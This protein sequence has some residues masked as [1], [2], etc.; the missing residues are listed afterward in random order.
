[1]TPDLKTKMSAEEFVAMERHTGL[2]AEW[3]DG[4][5]YAIAGGSHLHWLLATNIA[6]ELRHRLK[7]SESH[8]LNSGMRLKVATT[9]LYAHPD[10]TIVQGAA[11]FEDG[12]QDTLLNPKVLIEVL[13]DQTAAWD[14]GGKFWH[15]RQLES[16]SD[17]ILVS[18]ETRLADHYTRQPNGSWMLKTVEAEDGIIQLTSIKTQLPLVEVY[19]NTKVPHN[20]A[21][22]ANKPHHPQV[23]A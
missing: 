16:L 22:A 3:L 13:S 11:A 18:Q 1:M 20:Q 21:P 15:Y 5:V 8:V 14:R 12:N 17:Y 23:K 10:V 2:R 7:N 6:G 19:A 9:S 4:G